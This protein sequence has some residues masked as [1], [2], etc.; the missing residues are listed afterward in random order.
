MVLAAGAAEWTP[1]HVA[2][3][4]PAPPQAIAPQAEVAPQAELAPQAIT[5][6]AEVAAPADTQTPLP[7]DTVDSLPGGTSGEHTP[8]TDAG[9]SAEPLWQVQLPERQLEA[10]FEAGL[11]GDDALVKAAG[12][13]H[14]VRFGEVRRSRAS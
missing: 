6:Q 5:P 12:T 14:W 3:A 11:L 9:A 1:L 7:P 10:A 13:D 8:V 2:I 4:A